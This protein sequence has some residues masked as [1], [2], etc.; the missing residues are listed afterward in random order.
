MGGPVDVRNRLRK[1]RQDRGLSQKQLAERAG[2]SRQTVVGIESGRYLPTVGVALRLARALG[3]QVEDMFALPEAAASLAARPTAALR[4]SPGER[5]A[6]VEVRGGLVAFPAS[7]SWSMPLP[8]ADGV[9]VKID[10]GRRSSVWVQTLRDPSE[11]H[12]RIAAAGCDPALGLLAA[13]LAGRRAP[14]QLLWLDT[15]SRTALAM[16]QAGEVHLAGVHLWDE[17]THSYNLPAVTRAFPR[18]GVVL[19]HL[20]QWEQGF[21]VAPGNP[22]G[23]RRVSDLLRPDVRMVNREPGSGA[24]LLLD[25]LLQQEGIPPEAV[26]GYERVLVG[27][28]AVAQAVALGAADV[29]VSTRAAAQLYGLDFLP[30][31]LERF[32][33]V[34]ATDLL[35]DPRLEAVIDAM[36]GSEFRRQLQN[37][38]GYDASETGRVVR[39]GTAHR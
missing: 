12:G 29:G 21:V 6:L 22:L 27:H 5:V 31:S 20:A 25:R 36:C 30:M 3:C 2:V 34:V 18:G 17:K 32:D 28:L 10:V 33:L 15:G 26:S 35:G 4:R 7:A 13:L 39:V 37:V 19:I 11:L 14:T 24:R 1:L 9:L 23:I 38:A 8:P 16:L